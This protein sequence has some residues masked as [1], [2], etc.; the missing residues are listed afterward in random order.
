MDIQNNYKIVPVTEGRFGRLLL[1]WKCQSQRYLRLAYGTTVHIWWSTS[2]TV[3]GCLILK[4]FLPPSPKDKTKI[5]SCWLLAALQVIASWIAVKW[6]QVFIK[7]VLT[8]EP[9]AANIA[10]YH[11]VNPPFSMSTKLVNLII[12]KT[13][14]NFSKRD[15]LDPLQHKNH[16]YTISKPQEPVMRW[17]PIV[18][19]AWQ[20]K[21]PLPNHLLS[22]IQSN[23]SPTTVA[24]AILQQ[25]WS[26]KISFQNAKEKQKLYRNPFNLTSQTM[27]NPIKACQ[28]V[29]VV[30]SFQ[31]LFHNKIHW[32]SNSK[33][34]CPP[35]TRSVRPLGAA[36]GHSCWWI[37]VVKSYI[38]KPSTNPTWPQ[39]KV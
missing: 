11:E 5:C 30:F 16:W 19:A 3:H 8:K 38:G 32:K 34:W 1:R 29:P 39:E 33:H 23:R 7:R 17:S 26:T 20:I 27:S 12:C 6:Q 24:Y 9:R 21:L 2:P 35:S 36:V 22:S 13:S 25:F 15:P 37:E 14:T 31:K 28:D 18:P 4:S 10:V